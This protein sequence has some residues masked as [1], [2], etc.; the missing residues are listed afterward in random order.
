M[1]TGA[2]RLTQKKIKAI[3]IMRPPTGVK[4]IQKLTGSLA[5]LSRFI[6]RLAER[7]LPF[8]KL[9]RKSG[10]F[11]WT[12]EAEQAFRELKQYLTSLPILVALEPGETLYLYIAAAAEAVSM[13]LVAEMATPE[14]QGPENLEPASS[15]WT[16]QK[17]IYYVSEVFHEAKTRYLETPKLP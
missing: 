6:S 3:E 1:R 2:L 9:L 16:V 12:E 17:S 14:G 4:D 10:P 15:A 5:A 13:V 11:T 7:A 8:F